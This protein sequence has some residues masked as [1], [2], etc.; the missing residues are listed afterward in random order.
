MS[1]FS[2]LLVGVGNTLLRDEGLGAHAIDRLKRL[3]LPDGVSLV[4]CGTDL[5]SLE[6]EL[7]GQRR[8]IVVD[9]IQAGDVP[10][11]IHLLRESEFDKAEARSSSAHQMSALESAKLLKQ[12]CPEL[13]GA[14]MIF[15]G[16][17]PMDMSMG[18]CLSPPVEAAMPR[19]IDRILGLLDE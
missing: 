2:I 17:E 6:A 16:I 18:E 3:N 10:G 11:T 4:Q 19:L 5:L 14:E 1:R 13:A 8:I 9:A 12:V 15:V 7:A